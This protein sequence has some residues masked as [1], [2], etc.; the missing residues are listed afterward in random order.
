MGA[1]LF[2]FTLQNAKKRMFRADD[3]RVAYQAPQK[4]D[5]RVLVRQAGLD[6]SEW[7]IWRDSEL[8]ASA[9][10]PRRLSRPTRR[11]TGR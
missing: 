9:A 10:Q 2:E 5:E 1:A 11:W 8:P 3:A 7:P 4:I 6:S